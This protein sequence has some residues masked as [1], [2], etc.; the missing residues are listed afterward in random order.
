MPPNK[1]R[2]ARCFVDLPSA[3]S[4]IGRLVY[5]TSSNGSSS[6]WYDAMALLAKIPPAPAR[7]LSFLLFSR[8]FL[9]LCFWPAQI[10]RYANAERD[11]KGIRR[12]YA[13]RGIRAVHAG[14][15]QRC[16][17][18]APRGR[19]PRVDVVSRWRHLLRWCCHICRRRLICGEVSIDLLVVDG[20]IIPHAHSSYV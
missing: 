2:K 1:K 6:S 18:V 20:I 12:R 17:A 16:T 15:R 14:R 3:V 10:R 7:C 8:L 13:S 4:V 19:Q 9:P 5:S 11:S